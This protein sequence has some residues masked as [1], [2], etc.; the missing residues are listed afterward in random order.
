[1]VQRAKVGIERM[2]QEPTASVGLRRVL[3]S[4]EQILP[5]RA[6]SHLLI[7]KSGRVRPPTAVVDLHALM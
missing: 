4:E 1:M 6:R 2:S 7:R 3:M 5:L